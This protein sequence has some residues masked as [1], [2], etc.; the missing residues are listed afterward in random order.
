MEK[1]S[2][3]GQYIRRA[4]AAYSEG[5]QYW[6]HQ[7][8]LLWRGSLLPLGCAAAPDGPTRFARRN[9]SADFTTASPPSGSKLPRHGEICLQVQ[10]FHSVQFRVEYPCPSPPH[11]CSPPG[12]KPGVPVIPL[13]A[14]A[15]IWWPG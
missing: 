5:H 3:P 6:P 2:D 11:R 7:R 12:A 14:C 13:N 10:L 1:I 8:T 9:A 15:A 4:G